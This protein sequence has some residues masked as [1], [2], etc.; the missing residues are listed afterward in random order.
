M[1]DPRHP[2]SNRA[3][4]G[5]YAPG[6]TFKLVVA[7]A[8]LELGLITPETKLSCSGSVRLYGNVFHCHR[9]GG[10]GRSNLV[11]ALA[12][13]CN[14]YF[15]Q[16]APKLQIEAIARYAKLLGLG[17]KSGIDLPHEVSG[18]VPDPE[19]KRQAR[20]EPWYAGETVSV[21]VGQGAVLATAT[22]MAQLAATVATN[23]DVHRPTIFV[24]NLPAGAMPEAYPDVGGEEAE[25]QRWPASRDVA[26]RSRQ[27][28]FQC[29]QPRRHGRPGSDSGCRRE[30]Q[31]G[32]LPG[33]VPGESRA[34]PGREPSRAPCGITLGSSASRPS[35]QSR[36]RDCGARRA[37]GGWRHRGGADRP[38]S[39]RGLLRKARPKD[40]QDARKTTMAIH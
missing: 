40:E 12:Q 8:A 27:G 15:Y 5:S 35:A 7:A 34:V 36:D 26:R 28:M 9:A 16:L 33:R 31:D 24:R 10:H 21:A 6:S 23:G 25:R 19:W 14:S 3:I 39:A 29:R 18:L 37:R 30:R 11:E 13:S 20:G 22:Q 1:G 2:L 32:H 17:S 38:E 4:Q